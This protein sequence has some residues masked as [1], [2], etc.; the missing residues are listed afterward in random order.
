MSYVDSLL[1]QGIE[2]TEEEIDEI[3]LSGIRKIKTLGP[4]RSNAAGFDQW[5]QFLADV[6]EAK[7]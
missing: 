4:L 7:I 3:K 6:D 1:G 5:N 2:L